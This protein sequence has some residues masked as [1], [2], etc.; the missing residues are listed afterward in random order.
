MDVWKANS[1]VVALV[2]QRIDAAFPELLELKDGRIAVLMHQKAREKHG[3]VEYGTLKKAPPKL[4][5]LT[6]GL[7]KFEFELSLAADKW[8]VL[9]NA[10][11][12][13]VI[14]HLLCGLVPVHVESSNEVKY[15]IRPPDLQVYLKEIDLHGFWQPD[16]EALERAFSKWLGVAPKSTPSV[17]PQTPVASSPPTKPGPKLPP[18]KG[19]ASTKPRDKDGDLEG[20]DLVL[21]FVEDAPPL[22]N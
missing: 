22:S 19:T 20:D 15:E 7:V 8:E 18:K 12:I 11:R 2:G 5:L 16:S 14:D 10:Q 21:P 3:V 1:D 17:R 4:K 6:D 13:A 9:D